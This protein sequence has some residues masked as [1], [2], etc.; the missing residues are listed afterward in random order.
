MFKKMILIV[1]TTL[2]RYTCDVFL[3][4]V[5]HQDERGEVTWHNLMKDLRLL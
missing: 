1:F 2:W 4:F 5:P 3:L